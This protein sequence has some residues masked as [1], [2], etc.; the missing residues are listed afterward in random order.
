MKTKLFKKIKLPL[1][2]RGLGGGVLLLLALACTTTLHAQK[3]T[4]VRDYTYQAGEADSKLTA[5]AN[6]TTQMRNILL[7]EVGQYLHVERTLKQ[8]DTSEEF[9][10][11]I[12]AITAGIVEMKTLD[13][14][15]DGSTYY[16]KA[17]MAVDPKDLERRIAEVLNDKQ[18]TKGL[19]EAR[20]RTLAAEAEAAR[21]RKELAATKDE[22]QHL[23]LQKTYTKAADVLSAEEYF[24][25]GNNAREN[26]FNELAIK[27]YQKALELNPN[28]AG[29][30][31]NM[32]IAYA[33]LKNYHEAI[34][35]YKKAIDIDPNYASAYNNMGVTYAD[36]KNYYEAIRCYQK[37]IDIDP[38]YATTHM[39]M[40][41]AYDILKNYD[42]A[43]RCF[44][45][46]IK[47]YPN[48]ASAYHN[49]G[50]TYANLK[51]YHEAIRCCQKAIDIDS[52]IAWAAYIGM[53]VAYDNLKNYREAIRCYKK[54]IDLDPNDVDARVYANMGNAYYELGNKKEQIKNYQQAARLG[55]EDAQEWLR[56]NGYNW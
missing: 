1:L 8:D 39:N 28:H 32:G 52:S 47:I 51:N 55:H 21:L 31:N 22:Q 45:K 9:S 3:K 16:I 38:N 35:C 6:A 4:F 10:Q 20:K 13:E 54:A 43:I 15:W 56:E 44:Q 40:G 30:Y 46:A 19:E 27:Y 5:R 23:A 34:W 37:A 14:Q 53:A 25:K 11:K 49:M 2:R 26:G 48:Y 7:S 41:N 12:E 24:T 17:E 50:R 18:K 33:D 36:L 29:A 42:K